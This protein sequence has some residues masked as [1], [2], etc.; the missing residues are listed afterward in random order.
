MQVAREGYPWLGAER[1]ARP[2]ACTF[3]AFR[4]MFNHTRFTGVLALIFS[5]MALSG[6]AYG[7]GRTWVSSNDTVR[8]CVSSANGDMHAILDGQSCKSNEELILFPV[9]PAAHGATGATGPQ[10]D[11]GARGVAGAAGATGAQGL[12]GTQG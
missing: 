1:R 8:V 9:G 10:G 6:A 12:A 4:D 3:V 2:H 7:L 5:F 11:T